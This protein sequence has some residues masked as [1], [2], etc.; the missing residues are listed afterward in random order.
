MPDYYQIFE[1]NP[2]A[3]P[4][5]IKEQYRFLVQI[6]HPDK[7]QTPAG[8]V[9]AE[10]KLKQII[11]AYSILGDPVKRTQYDLARA[12]TP[13]KYSGNSTP[14][15]SA[16][17]WSEPQAWA[18]PARSA[19]EYQKKAAQ[20][21]N[22]KTKN[23]PAW[24]FVLQNATIKKIG[25]VILITAIA[26]LGFKTILA[27]LPGQSSTPAQTTSGSTQPEPAPGNVPQLPRATVTLIPLPSKTPLPKNTADPATSSIRARDGMQM[28]FVP[29]GS[30]VMGSDSKIP[31]HQNENPAHAV[32]LDAFWIDQT[33]VTNAMYAQCVQAN[34]CQPPSSS[35]SLAGNEYYGVPKFS[36]F[37]VTNVSRALANT[38]CA[39]VDG[40]LPG[41]AEWE[42]AARGPDG[43]TYPW[44]EGIDPE[45]ANY[46]RNIGDT[47]RVGSYPI[48]S[49]PYGAEDMAGNV[50][51]WVADYVSYTGSNQSNAK[52]TETLGIMRGGYWGDDG[53][54]VRSSRRYLSDPAK[55]YAYTGFRCAR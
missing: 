26:L 18:E 2:N 40:R 12:G 8:K 53:D 34:A 23:P 25:L 7:I 16:R 22:P 9:K 27:V 6:W 31:G 54:F 42:K 47:T 32:N 49:S 43:R 35:K 15:D 20:A 19:P 29:A 38:Y 33:E 48:G 30:F 36:D 1:L 41:E 51:E 17:H 46:D 13:P 24:D 10:E 44:G 11:E 14:T 21:G 37:P 55:D 3:T 28:V 52:L 4:A 39:W 45:H 50:M 5:Q